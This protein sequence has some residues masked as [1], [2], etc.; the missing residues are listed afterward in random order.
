[1]EPLNLD[2]VVNQLKN[3]NALNSCPRCDEY[4][5][6]IL[7]ES[8]I[9]VKKPQGSGLL[10]SLMTAET[11]I[12]TVMVICNNCGYIAHHAL[13]TLSTPSEGVLSHG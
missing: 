10:G 3:K 13:A 11:P 1:M 7:G 5:F 2:Q 8:E 12:A 6:S 4:N 9:V